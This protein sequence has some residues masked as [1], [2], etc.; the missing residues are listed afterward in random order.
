[1]DTPLANV[2][3]DSP[4]DRILAVGGGHFQSTRLRYFKHTGH[5]FNEPIVGSRAQALPLTAEW[6]EV[7]RFNLTARGYRVEVRFL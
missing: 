2:T 4:K 6:A 1:M 3:M 5:K 7:I